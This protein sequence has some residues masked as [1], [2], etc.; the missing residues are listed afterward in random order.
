MG[1]P[2]PP[3]PRIIKPQVSG[4]PPEAS[5]DTKQPSA[6]GKGRENLEKG[7]A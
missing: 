7:A 3:R 2:R 5:G 4:G 6:R 1:L